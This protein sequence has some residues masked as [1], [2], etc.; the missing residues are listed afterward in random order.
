MAFQTTAFDLTPAEK[1]A[2]IG[3]IRAL[4]LSA[5]ALIARAKKS[6]TPSSHDYTEALDMINRA[7]FLATDSD[8]CDPSHPM[9]LATCYLYKGHIH[10][11]LGNIAKARAA[12]KKAASSHTRR[13]TDSETSRDEAK[14]LLECLDDTVKTAQAQ[15]GMNANLACESDTKDQVDGKPGKKATQVGPDGITLPVT[16]RPGPAKKPVF[17]EGPCGR[18]F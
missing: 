17:G 11:A 10:L 3:Q 2:I 12:Y 16:L 1:H 9:P 6:A 13:F 4:T 14:R 8:A 7:L 18:Y 5:G 15:R